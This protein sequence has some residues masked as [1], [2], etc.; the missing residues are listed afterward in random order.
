MVGDFQTNTITTNASGTLDRPRIHEFLFATGNIVRAIAI[1]LNG[2]NFGAAT[3]WAGSVLLREVNLTNGN[4]GVFLLKNGM[5]T[6]VSSFFGG[7]F[8][9][10]FTG[11]LSNAFPVLGTGFTN[12]SFATNGF[13]D[14]FYYDSTNE[15]TNLSLS[16][17]ANGV[18]TTFTNSD[19]NIFTNGFNLATPLV[20]GRVQTIGTNSTT[21]F[22]RT[23]GLYYLSLNTTNIKFSVVGAGDGFITPVAGAISGVVY[24]RPIERELDWQ[25]RGVFAPGDD[26]YL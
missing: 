3:N 9:N 5:Q 6:N 15:L 23:A 17:V 26:Q 11:G 8:S 2:T 7:S 4:E 12:F 16:V 10:N 18:T 21:N 22:S 1:D 24:Q 13:T 19:T 25:R 20:E 14:V